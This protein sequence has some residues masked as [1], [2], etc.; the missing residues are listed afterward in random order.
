MIRIADKCLCSAACGKTPLTVI[1]RGPPFLLADEE[2][3]P[4]FVEK[5]TAEILLRRLTDQN[6][7]IQRIFHSLSGAVSG[8][9]GGQLARRIPERVG[10]FWT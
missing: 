8:R 3:S 7:S 1:L 4:Q 6:D 9:S 10:G 2:G 5:T